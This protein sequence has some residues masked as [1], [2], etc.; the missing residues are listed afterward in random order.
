MLT[1]KREGILSHFALFDDT[2]TEGTISS[3]KNSIS[4]SGTNIW[5]L[6]CAAVLASIG[7][8]TNSTAVIIGAMLVSPLMSPI[9][10]IGLGV[11]INDRNL[12]VNAL[13]N[14]GIAI[15]LSLLTSTLYFS[16]TPIKEVTDELIARTTPTILDVGIAFFGGVAGIVAGS[17]KEKTNALPGVAIATALMPP[18][19]TAGFGLATGQP[20]IFLGAIYL[21]FINAFFISLATYLIVR[22]LKFP[23]VEFADSTMRKKIKIRIAAFAIIVIIPS[24][25]IFY[26]VIKDLRLKN[27][28]KNFVVGKINSAKRSVLRWEIVDDNEQKILRMYLFGEPFTAT[29]IKSLKQE[30][31]SYALDTFQ[32]DLIQMNIP[33]RE[34]QQLSSEIQSNILKNVMVIQQTQEKQNKEKETTIQILEAQLKELKGDPTTIQSIQNEVKIIFPEIASL[35]YTPIIN[36]TSGETENSS[37]LIIVKFNRPLRTPLQSEIKGKLELFLKQRLQVDSIKVVIDQ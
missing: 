30:Q 4:T 26:N 29:E 7:L 31:L 34:R 11:G 37:H 27:N 19:C 17:R 32:L 22:F 16:V 8:N 35:L 20:T 23:F 36:L 3:I 6:I 10:G 5:M 33:E 13:K 25:F 18:L 24:T 14:F 21:F 9:L 12:L 1:D 2:D 15:I 28:I